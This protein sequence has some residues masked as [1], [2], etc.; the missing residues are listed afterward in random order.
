MPPKTGDRDGEPRAG[1]LLAGIFACEVAAAL[2]IGLANRPVLGLL[3]AAAAV[4][5]GAA[6]TRRFRRASR[7]AGARQLAAAWRGAARAAADGAPAVAIAILEE[8]R[9]RAGLDGPTARLLVE[10]HASTDQVAHA[11]EVAVENLDLLD[12]ADVGNMIA[13]L[14]SWGERRHVAALTAAIG[15]QRTATRNRR[16]NGNSR[17][18]SVRTG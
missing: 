3:F 18:P 4:W 5:L 9:S 2:L 14:E 17:W 12:P 16:G 7:A 13:S 11:V 10:L 15:V 1:R 8:A 6:G